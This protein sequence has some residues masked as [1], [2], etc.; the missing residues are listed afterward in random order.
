MIA[1]TSQIEISEDEIEL[2]FKRSPGPGGQH[3]NKVETA[4]ELRFGV[5]ASP[6]LDGHV[7]A[8]LAH[9]AGQRLTKEGVIVIHADRF[10]SQERNREDALGRLI[11]LI[12][13]AAVVP[14]TRR[15]TKPSRAAKRRR[16]ETKQK[17]GAVKKTRGRVKD[18]D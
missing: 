10:R 5:Y 14:K 18:S 12:R 4:V 15:P 11:E 8:R 3:V 1:V 13:K 7:K 9:L 2:R 6:S 16:V 17:R